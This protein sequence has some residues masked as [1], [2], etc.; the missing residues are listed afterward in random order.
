MASFEYYKDRAFQAVEE[1]FGDEQ[2]EGESFLKNVGVMFDSKESKYRR[3]GSF[4]RIAKGFVPDAIQEKYRESL[5]DISKLP[6]DVE[7]FSFERRV[8]GGAEG[9]VYL[10]ESKREESPSYV[11]KVYRSKEKETE[12]LLKLAATKKGEYERM[13][14]R[15][16]DIPELIPE[17]RF[18]IMESPKKGE[19]GVVASVQQFVGYELHDLFREPIEEIKKMCSENQ[20]LRQNIKAFAQI[21]QETLKKE[22]EVPDLMGFK[23][24]SLAKEESGKF[25]LVFLDPHCSCSSDPEETDID[26]FKRNSQRLDNLLNIAEA[27]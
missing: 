19:G 14:E 16:R 21:T 10:L 9:S 13:R 17:E 23:N 26:A 20:D 6:F 7:A 1:V 25:H 4:L 12:D 2:Q 8:G 5:Y 3:L 18:I 27:V 11:F 22:K 24:V 15:Y